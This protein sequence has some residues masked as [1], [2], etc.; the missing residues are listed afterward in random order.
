MKNLLF[1]FAIAF[2][3]VSCDKQYTEDL[4]IN[5]NSDNEDVMLKSGA[6]AQPGDNMKVY[7]YQDISWWG[8]YDA[9]A[10]LTAFVGIDV[11]EFCASQGTEGLDVLNFQD[12]VKDQGEDAPRIHSLIKG[13]DVSFS[14]WSGP[15]VYC[16]DLVDMVQMGTGHLVYT[17]ND[18]VSYLNEDDNVNVWGLRFN[19]E[20]V[21]IKYRAMWD[22][23][24]P[25]TFMET[26]SIKVK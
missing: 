15:V 7:R 4:P 24:D 19:G 6:P 22:G 2:F 14:V 1:V 16:S 10:D 11:L 8:L 9:E 17:D 5:P 12:I 18:V 13:K 23:D 20:G 21:N 26:T 25:L 3:L